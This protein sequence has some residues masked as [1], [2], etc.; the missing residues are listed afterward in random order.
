[1]RTTPSGTIRASDVLTVL[2][3][4]GVAIYPSSTSRMTFN[5]YHVRYLAGR[6][7][8]R[9]SMND[10]RN[11]T[12]PASAGTVLSQYC[13]GGTLVQTIADGRYGS[14][15]NNIAN[16]PSCVVIIPGQVF[17]TGAGYWQTY[18]LPATSAPTINVVL[19]G[20]GGGGG[21]GTN[22]TA[23]TG[24]FS[25]GGGGASGECRRITFYGIPPGASFSYYI[26][27]GGGAGGGR[28]GG[29]SGGSNG[30]TGGDTMIYYNGNLQCT[31]GGGEGGAVSQV[32]NYPYLSQTTSGIGGR[33]GTTQT[34]QRF[35]PHQGG[36]TPGGQ[37][38]LGVGGDWVYPPEPGGYIDA[39]HSFRTFDS[40][41]VLPSLAELN[42]W[43]QGGGYGGRGYDFYNNYRTVVTGSRS[44]GALGNDR[45][46]WSQLYQFTQQR[47]YTDFTTY[48]LVN[49]VQ[50]SSWGAGGGG[51]SKNNE[52]AGSG[53]STLNG[54]NG[55]QGAI[56]IYWDT[57]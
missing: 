13:N 29:Y 57:V 43:P 12:G 3:S 26:G 44:A 7:N 18:T 24:R 16:S 50:S 4:G 49:G 36:H 38:R 56:S 5:D 28:D 46:P 47:L 25:G 35:Y 9:I 32:V 27:P 54:T 19:V 31:A 14:Y 23:N 48:G 6:P 51:G 33:G 42:N 55:T 40:W 20:G 10:M 41:T 21:G 39:Y 53:G 2:N 52:Y 30:T 45:E 1:M 37:T 11:K 22:R 34:V 8:G 15:I 17:L